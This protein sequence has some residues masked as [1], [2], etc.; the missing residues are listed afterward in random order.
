MG[1]ANSTYFCVTCLT[2][3]S[4]VS[5][6]SEGLSCWKC[7][8]FT[9]R[10]LFK[11]SEVRDIIHSWP[12]HGVQSPNHYLWYMDQIKAGPP[13]KSKSTKRKKR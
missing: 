7:G 4:K 11:R 3:D 9:D 1:S 8:E 12:G 5:L 13:K 10:T 6:V 2:R